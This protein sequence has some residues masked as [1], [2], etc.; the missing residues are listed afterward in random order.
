MNN[1]LIK[2]NKLNRQ[3]LIVDCKVFAVRAGFQTVL[4]LL[5]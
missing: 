3:K 2:K 1:F 5:G 4:D